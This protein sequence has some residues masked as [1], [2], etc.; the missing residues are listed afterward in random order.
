MLGGRHLE[1][2]RDEVEREY[3]GMIGEQ[4]HGKNWSEQFN[5][6]RD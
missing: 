1:E 3:R 4:E 2:R 5:E 6:G